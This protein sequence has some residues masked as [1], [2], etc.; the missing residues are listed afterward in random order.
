MTD[1]QILPCECTVDRPHVFT[2]MGQDGADPDALVP[3]AWKRWAATNL[4]GGQ[5][6]QRLIDIM[7]EQGFDEACA[8]SVCVDLVGHP[9]VGA[10]R[11]I[12]DRL[13]K[14]ESILDVRQKL[15]SL[16]AVGSDI[17]SRSSVSR[18]EFL[19]DYY[20]GNLPVKLTD[21][22]TGWE[23][24][25]KWSPTFLKDVIGSEPVEIMAGRESDARFEINAD[26]HKT[27][28]RFA[29][30]VDH[31]TSAEWSND[32]YLVANNHLLENAAATALWSDF[33]IDQRYLDPGNKKGSI[34]LWFGPAGTVTPLHHDV[35]NILFVQVS[36]RKRVR[37][38]SPLDTHCLYNEVAVYSEV[39]PS[40]PDM[41][42]HPKFA[43]TRQFQL[44]MEPGDALF[45]PAGWWHHVT[46]LDASISLSF[47]NFLWPNSFSWHQPSADNR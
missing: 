46:A 10:G 7:V 33:A 47:T 18:E 11:R 34:F 29:E 28:M 24:I 14:L 25:G 8:Y 35:A 40:N 19:D 6:V 3:Y 21:V 31:V 41:A 5:P 27:T 37:L 42:R 12:A 23:A 16:S 36:G 22:T 39:D 9:A 13:G 45:I 44:E 43:R 30:Y 26:A 17:E 4:I 15:R 32:K 2:P 38:I 20:S 1:Q